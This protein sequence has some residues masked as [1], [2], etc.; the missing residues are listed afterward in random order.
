MDRC[1]ERQ[2]QSSTVDVGSDQRENFEGWLRV[3]LF[4][5]LYQAEPERT[6]LGLG[7]PY[8]REEL[9]AGAVKGM[10]DVAAQRIYR[11]AKDIFLA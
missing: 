2:R 4:S 6:R 5:L 8:D 3:Y 7:T 1:S 11:E 9:R 10:A